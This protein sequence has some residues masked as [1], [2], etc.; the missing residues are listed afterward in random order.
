MSAT[1]QDYQKQIAELQA[2][3]EEARRNEVAGARAKIQSIMREYGLTVADISGGAKPPKSAR[4]PVEIKYKDG[5]TGLTWTGRG[6]APKWLEG[7][8]KNQFL[9]R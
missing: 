1:Y 8:D 4:K 7:K 9:V 3:A 6:R 5:A 2:K